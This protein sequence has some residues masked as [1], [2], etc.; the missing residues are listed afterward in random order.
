MMVCDVPYVMVCDVQCVSL[1][2]CK[3]SPVNM[4]TPAVSICTRARLHF[5]FGAG[6]STTS[7]VTGAG[8]T[9]PAAPSATYTGSGVM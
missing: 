7:D 9:A 6:P 5:I 4:G 1:C 2:W 3:V 8:A